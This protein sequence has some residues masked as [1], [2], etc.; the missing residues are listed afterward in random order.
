MSLRQ[1]NAHT[2]HIFM[3]LKLLKFSDILRL[4]ELKWVFCRY[5][6]N[7]LPHFWE[8]HPFQLNTE[9]HDYTT[10]IQHKITNNHLYAKHC[11]HFDVPIVINN[12][13]KRFKT[14]LKWVTVFK[15]ILDTLECK[16][17]AHLEGR[18]SL[19]GNTMPPSIL[20]TTIKSD[21]CW[22]HCPIWN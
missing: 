18:H 15:A 17:L 9:I 11:M 10:N 4:H 6:N 8:N 3:K 21:Y 22:T 13:P 12:S 14:I 2:E 16:L 20:P 1:Y 5:K 7:K 19:G